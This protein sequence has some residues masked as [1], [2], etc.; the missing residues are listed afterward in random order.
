VRGDAEPSD[1]YPAEAFAAR[2]AGPCKVEIIPDCDH[3]YVG[4]E[5]AVSKIVCS[6][7]ADAIKRA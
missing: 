1:L 4:R 6:W 2:A 5:A 7:L 3:F